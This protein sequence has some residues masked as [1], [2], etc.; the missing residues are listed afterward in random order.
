MPNKMQFQP[1]MP[2]QQPMMNGYGQQVPMQQNLFYSQPNQM[3]SVTT[4]Q[5]PPNQTN[6]P[7][8]GATQPPVANGKPE[9]K[10]VLNS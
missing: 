4:M 7:Q 5:A 10:T 2:M 3:Q 6:V 1:P 9:V 8:Q